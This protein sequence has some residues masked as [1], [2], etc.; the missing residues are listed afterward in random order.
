M[1]VCSLNKF[2]SHIN[3]TPIK[4]LRVLRLS[5][6][7]ITTTLEVGVV[8]VTPDTVTSVA[9]NSLKIALSLEN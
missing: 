5:N 9:K 2:L 4:L 6:Q 3:N 7:I 8:T 1:F